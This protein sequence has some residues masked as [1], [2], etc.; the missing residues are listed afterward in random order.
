M[1]RLIR[2]HEAL[3]ELFYRKTLFEEQE[4]NCEAIAKFVGA[5]P[6]GVGKINQPLNV[7][8]LIN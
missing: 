3:P 1:D 4:K 8:K 5:E 7:I 6:N 2:E